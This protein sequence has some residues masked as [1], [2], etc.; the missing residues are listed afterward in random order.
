MTVEDIKRRARHLRGELLAE[1]AQRRR[2][3]QRR[4][5]GAAQVPRHLP[6]GRPRR[7]PRAG[8]AEAAAR[9]LVHGPR[10]GA[11]RAAHARAVAGPRPTGRAHRRHAAPHDPPG[12]AVPRRAQGRAAGNRRRDQRR[13][14]DDARRV[15][16][17]R[18]QRHGLPGARARAPSSNPSSTRSSPASARGRLLL[19]AVGRR[20][21]GG[22][23]R[24]R[25]RRTDGPASTTRPGG[26]DPEPVYGD[27]YLPRKFKIGVAWPG[28][29]N[30]DVYGNDVG[31][32]PTLTDGATARLTGFN[33]L[34][35]GGLGRSHARDDT[36]P[37]LASPLGWVTPDDLVDVVEAI[38]TTQRDHGNRDDRQRARLKYLVDERGIAWVRA[39]GG[40]AGGQGAR[41][42]GRACRR[43]RPRTITASTASTMGCRCPTDE[44]ATTTASTC[45]RRCASSPP[46]ARSPD[47]PRHAPPG[48]A[49]RRARPRPAGDG[50]GPPPRAT[51]S[52]SPATSAPL[53]RLAI[54][55]PALPTCGQ[56]LGEAERVLP[57]VVDA[58]EKV[59]VRPG[60]GDEPIRVN[61]TGC[62]NGC[63]RPYT[64]E[65]GIVG[66]TKKTYDL[67]V[68]G[69]TAGD[70]LAQ[71]S[72]PTSVS[73]TS[74]RRCARSSRATPP[75]AAAGDRP[76]SATGPRPQRPRRLVAWLPEPRSAAGVQPAAVTG[77]VT[78]HLVGAGPGDPD[79]LTVRAGAPAGRGRRRRPRRPRRR[80]RARPRPA[81][82]RAD[83]R[84]QAAR[85]AGA[86]GADLD[87][88]RRARPRRPSRR[89]AEGRRPVRV[90]PRR[91]GGARPLEAGVE[92]EVV[93]GITSSVAAPAA[94]GVPVTH[95][96]VS[97]VVHRRHRPPRARRARRRLASLAK[98]GGTVVV[99]MGVTQRGAIAA[100]LIAGGLPGHARRRRP[101]G[102]DGRRGRAA[103]PPRR[104]RRSTTSTRPP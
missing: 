32:V 78:V 52:P 71:P 61:M 100:E 83:R 48:S 67:Y 79:L 50:R 96:G 6:A 70:R 38:V 81:D 17:R 23:R 104:A 68:G 45:A 42:P 89:A 21:Q 28:D 94:A 12:R 97:A 58:M 60:H 95:R 35:G 101:V 76:S 63:A 2:T 56:A 41:R 98:V 20:R 7:P 62:P 8:L 51:A 33:V 19:G 1:V 24:A 49:A 84:R 47:A 77:H 44:F 9:L 72:A 36:Y 73:T 10:L 30:I 31:I 55:C 11:R 26:D 88:A 40:G 27:V 15:R 25:R 65:I 29:N 91:R 80:R 90:R 66:R 39:A 57:D 22:Q 85:P 16:R 53:R 93:P 3:V 86:A 43:G 87:A 5:P 54:A 82:R 46:T 103:L 74:R 99:L 34:V 64:A 92:F 13:R 14:A 75:I 59:L 37:R 69:S 18:P 102:D 4:Q